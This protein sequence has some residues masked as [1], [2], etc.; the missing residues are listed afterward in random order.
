MTPRVS[1]HLYRNS[2]DRV[3][4]PA[5]VAGTFYPENPAQLTT[6]IDR[7]L[8]EAIGPPTKQRESGSR[9]KALIGPH[10]GYI[11]SG[12]VAASAYK[13][14]RSYAASISRVVLLGPAHRVAIRAMATSGADEWVTPLGPVTIDNAGREVALQ[15]PGVII[16][17]HAHEYEHSLEVQLPFLQHVLGD[18][19]ELIPIVIGVVET[20]TVANLIEGLWGGPETLIVV[21]TDLSHFQDSQT[22]QRLDTATAASIVACDSLAI[23]PDL[24]CGAYPLSGLLTVANNRGMDVEMLDLRTSAE[25]NGNSESVVGYGAFA[26]R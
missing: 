19:W 8:A 23:R 6:A 10:A 13:T 21:S 4:R 26:L 12:I 2:Q 15:I 22:A 9:P 1:R 16:D 18:T 17:D 24:A 7:A 3:V 25:I 14:L 11:Y 5:A 20:A